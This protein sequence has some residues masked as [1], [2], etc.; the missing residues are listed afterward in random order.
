[1]K[2]NRRTIFKRIFAGTLGIL[3]LSLANANPLKAGS[4]DSGQS[5][6]VIMDQDIPLFS[7]SQTYGGLV[8]IAGIGAHFEGDITSHTAHVMEEMKKQ[9]EKAGS[10]MDRVLKVNVYLNDIKEWKAMNAV[11]H[12]KFG[13]NPPVRTTIA[14]PGGIPGDSLV[15]MDC[16][17][18]LNAK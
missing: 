4:D 2:T 1:M 17:A 6:D 3:G 15:E 10:S 14:A 18:A 8:Y 9:L 7:S 13:K 5:G 12:G 11:F 16:I